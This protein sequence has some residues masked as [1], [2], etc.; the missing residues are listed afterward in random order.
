MAKVTVKVGVNAASLVTLPKDVNKYSIERQQRTKNKVTW[1]GGRNFSIL[2]QNKRVH[3]LTYINVSWSQYLT[4][5]TYANVSRLW[6]VEISG[7]GSTKF[8]SGYAYLQTVNV[9]V[10]VVT[11]TDAKLS[12]SLVIFE[13]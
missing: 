9:D 5:L 3:N 8:F 13:N 12:F 6:Y 7:F 11:D 1:S 10:D 2:G 4:F